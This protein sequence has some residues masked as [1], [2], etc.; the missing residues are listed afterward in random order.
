M[1][2]KT[3]ILTLNLHVSIEDLRASAA[4]SSFLSYKAAIIQEQKIVLLCI[5]TITP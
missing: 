3:E 5:A 4:I 1:I 2:A